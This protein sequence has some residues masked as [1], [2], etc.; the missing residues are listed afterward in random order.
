MRYSYL[1]IQ[2]IFFTCIGSERDSECIRENDSNP[3]LVMY[4]VVVS[5]LANIFFDYLA[6]FV[7]HWE[8]SAF[9]LR[10]ASLKHSV[11]FC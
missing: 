3:Q 2:F 11:L 10:P 7:L 8:C 4:S 5:S 1:K 9:R 6:I